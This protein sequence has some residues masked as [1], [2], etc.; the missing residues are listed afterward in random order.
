MADEPAMVV[1]LPWLMHHL[2]EAVDQDIFLKNLQL[3]KH[4]TT[5][6]L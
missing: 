1:M 5:T 3:G 2:S 6:F 4:R